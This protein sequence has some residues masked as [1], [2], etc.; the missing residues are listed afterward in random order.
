MKF[1]N[2]ALLVAGVVLGVLLTS[3]LAPYLSAATTPYVRLT[4]P[5]IKPVAVADF[6]PEQKAAVGANAR[7]NLNFRTALYEPEF[8]KRWWS[9]LVFVWNSD[10]RVG[11][12]LTL[13]DKELV[14]LRVNWLCHD[15]WVWGQHVPIAKRNGRTDEDV[16]RIPKGPTADGWTQKDRLLM[17]AVE[18][19]HEDQFISDETWDGL[20][21]IYNTK[22]MIDLIFTVGNYHTN[23]MYTNSVGMPFEKGFGGLP[24]GR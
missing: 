12:A 19:L 21:R 14:V 10:S 13:Y 9:W 4:T 3:V 7:P 1:R 20:S 16:A 22:Q 23:A 5:R 24:P 11:S 2:L 8:G 17:Q 18:E 15:D 6:T